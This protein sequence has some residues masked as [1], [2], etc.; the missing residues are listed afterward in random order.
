VSATAVLYRSRALH[1][2]A[3]DPSTVFDP[4][5]DCYHEDVDVGLRL[6]RVGWHSY[7]VPDA[8]CRH[9]G[10]STGARLGWRHSWWLLAN[11]WR[12]IAGNLGLWPTLAATPAAV[13]GELRAAVRMGLRDP[14]TLPVAGLVAAAMPLL[15]L[16]GWRRP[17]PG[18]R[19]RRLPAGHR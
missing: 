8:L 4:N 1:D 7:W 17:S 14:R 12:V 5:F 19:L 15:L 3:L 6:T 16:S 10:S 13:W 2:V 11:P 18:H 9:L